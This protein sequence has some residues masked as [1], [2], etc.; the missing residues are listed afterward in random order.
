MYYVYTFIRLLGKG[1]KV[2]NEDGTWKFMGFDECGCCQTCFLRL[3]R[4][5]LI[6]ATYCLANVPVHR[7]CGHV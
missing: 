6:L 7:I 4:N 5:D 3:V 1:L 2:L